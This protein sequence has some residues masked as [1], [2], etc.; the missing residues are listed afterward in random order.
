MLKEFFFQFFEY[1]TRDEED[2][3]HLFLNC[4][5]RKKSEV[6]EREREID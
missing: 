4:I 5:M 6:R 1:E 3:Q 2:T